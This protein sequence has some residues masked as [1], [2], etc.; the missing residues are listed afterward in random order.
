[1]NRS[2]II[3][4]FVL[5]F[6][7]VTIVVG[8][9]SKKKGAL[10]KVR[11][12][13]TLRSD[14]EGY[15][16]TNGYLKYRIIEKYGGEYQGRIKKIYYSPG[17]SFKKGDKLMEIGDSSFLFDLF[18]DYARAKVNFDSLEVEYN[19][20]LSVFDR[21][22]ISLSEMNKLKARYFEAKTYYEN[23]KFLYYRNSGYGYDNGDF[24]VR[25][26]FNGK[27]LSVNYQDGE[28]LS[29]VQTIMEVSR[30]TDMYA[31][32][33]VNILDSKKI[34]VGD[35]VSITSDVLP[36][37]KAEGKIESVSLIPRQLNET[38]VIEVHAGIEMS[39]TLPD[40]IP[41]EGKIVYEVL[42]DVL[43]IPLESLSEN[44]N[45]F[46]NKKKES[47]YYVFVVKPED[48]KKR[49]GILEKRDVQIGM[50]NDF[51]AEITDGLKEGEMVVNYS[52][53]PVFNKED[54]EYE[55]D[56]TQEDIKDL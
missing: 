37:F 50:Q 25:A 36:S 41:I 26:P 55:I 3:L 45:Y 49:H 56:R 15:I 40:N 18:T 32:L 42:K 1:M 34:K 2:R 12:V 35:P 53:K 29:K 8:I 44:K 16:F 38:Q 22:G 13:E 28:N 24:L 19:G 9:F 33:N 5:I 11:C 47:L 43:S 6:I 21:G 27:V 52:E 51:F 23:H 17:Q 4:Y 14:F 31:V 7:A 39:E 54:V 48:A 30:D 46:K 10:E 20:A